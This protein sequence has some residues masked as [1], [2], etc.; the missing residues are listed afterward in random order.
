MRLLFK[1]ADLHLKIHWNRHK[2]S[3]VLR[4]NCPFLVVDGF[5]E[6]WT[7]N[8]GFKHSLF[9][10]KL[11]FFGKTRYKKPDTLTQWDF[12]NIKKTLY[13]LTW[14]FF[15]KPDN[16]SRN[17]ILSEPLRYN[18]IIFDTGHLIFCNFWSEISLCDPK[19]SLWWVDQKMAICSWE[20]E[21]ILTKAQRAICLWSHK[22][23][24]QEWNYPH[25]HT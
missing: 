10:I 23:T 24:L 17:P 20:P 9:F 4:G 1:T 8:G 7:E 19:I 5:S 14:Y 16:F 22:N 25:N 11:A 2:K 3:K 13:K 18:F 6:T 12:S 15:S 21:V